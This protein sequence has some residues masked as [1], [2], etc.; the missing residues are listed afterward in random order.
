MVRNRYKGFPGKF[1]DDMPGAE[2]LWLVGKPGEPG[3]RTEP[4]IEALWRN[5]ISLFYVLYRLG[6]WVHFGFV[7]RE[8]CAA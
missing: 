7:R 3:W 2:A 1:F 6:S 5:L 8:V 4:E